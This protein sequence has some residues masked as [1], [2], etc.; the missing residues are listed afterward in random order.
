[1]PEKIAYLN[2]RSVSDPNLV[3]KAIEAAKLGVVSRNLRDDLK[4]E[5]ELAE[6]SP[7]QLDVIRL[8]ADGLSNREIAAQRDTSER[9]VES[10]LQRASKV[11]GIEQS[12]E[13]N[14]RVRVAKA[15]IKQVGSA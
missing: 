1:M 14:T 12:E 2:K 10:L 15:Y 7:A 9:A 13:T 5:H 4:G 11:L 3:V 8:V 6:F